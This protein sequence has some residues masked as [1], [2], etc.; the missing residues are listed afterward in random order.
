MKKH[1]PLHEGIRVGQ[2]IDGKPLKTQRLA[3]VL[4]RESQAI[5]MVA[6]NCRHEYLHLMRGNQTREEMKKAKRG[7]LFRH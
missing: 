6:A 7:R 2:T 5:E 1:R 4:R 3:N